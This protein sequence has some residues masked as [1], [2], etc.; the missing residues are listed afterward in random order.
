MT[1]NVVVLCLDTVREDF[2]RT[3]ASRLRS[4]ADVTFTGC[5]AAS[6]WS[7]PSHASMLTGRL[8]TEH[9]VHVHAPDF[10]RLVGETV[11]D[12]LEHRS[13]GISANVY[14]GPT[15]GFDA[16]FD[17]F[18]AVSRYRR[19]PDGLDP[20]GFVDEHADEGVQTFLRLAREIGGHDHPLLSLANLGLYRANDLIRHGPLDGPELFDDGAAIVARE[21]LAGTDEEPFVAFANVMDAHEPH[22]TVR[23]YDN[24]AHSVPNDWTSEGLDNADVIRAPE[25]HRS[26]IRNYR[27][28]YAAAIEYLD[29]WTVHLVDRLRERTDRET[30]IVVTADHGENL[31]YLAED[32]L[33][34]HLGSLSE[35]LLHVPL[36]LVNPPEGYPDR[37]DGYVS[38]LELP[39]LIRG[40]ARGETPDVTRDR[41][42]AEVVG[43]TPSNE[44]LDGD[45]WDRLRRCVYEGDRKWI[46]DSLGNCH[47]YRLDPAR[48]NW[49]ERRGAD[50][51]TAP[52]W[53]EE[54]FPESIESFQLADDASAPPE[55]DHATRSRLEELGYL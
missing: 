26:D 11:F 37:I 39:E 36:V 1:R 24:A 12:D 42:A 7:T 40:L 49:Q 29:R 53:A 48:P 4:E 3:F 13:I 47:E 15:Y 30:T 27:T 35:G 20:V 17:E 18:V 21:T 52:E 14:A 34:G 9:G 5:R 43:L 55:I 44:E 50:P 6:A 16:L 8:P 33:F 2:F 38:H 32:G 10:Q 23:N 45:D 54:F 46:W 51:A 31:A 22:R 25:N 19:Y 41:V 28:L